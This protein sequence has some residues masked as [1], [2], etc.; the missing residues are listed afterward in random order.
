MNS[1]P[2]IKIMNEEEITVVEFTSPSVSDVE[3]ICKSAHLLQEFLSLNRPSRLVFDFSQVTFFSSQVFGL[4]LET[5]K[6]L[7]EW[8]GQVV[9][10]GINTQLEN[11][12]HVTNLNKV[13][14]FFQDRTA[15][16]QSV[17]GS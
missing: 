12:F 6:K 8:K 15:A 4:L 14:Q 11:V 16:I 1:E 2:N 13:F 5:R 3:S 10:S 9:L 7:L 17:A